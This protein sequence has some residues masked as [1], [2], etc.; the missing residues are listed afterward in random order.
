MRVSKQTAILLKE[1]GYD[2]AC[3]AY[4]HNDKNGN[5]LFDIDDEYENHN[6]FPQYLHHFYSAPTLH[7]AS[8][9]LRS[10]GA[11]VYTEPL[12]DGSKGWIGVVVL[13]ATFRR[14]DTE[15]FNTYEAAYEAG[16]V[17]GLKYI[18]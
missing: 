11:H 2:V 17:H 14:I 3:N 13:L 9:W 7:E 1:A 5:T 6:S 16:I 8:D 4:Y 10:N 15:K 18:K 12:W